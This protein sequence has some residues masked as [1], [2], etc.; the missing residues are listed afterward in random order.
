M[1]FSEGISL[2]GGLEDALVRYKLLS[3]CRVRVDNGPEA[4]G[5]LHGLLQA[6]GEMLHGKCNDCAG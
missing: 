5:V 6:P 2:P 1:R 3:E 4:L